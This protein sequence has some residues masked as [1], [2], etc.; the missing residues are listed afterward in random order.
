MCLY[1]YTR[2][3]WEHT[4]EKS[5]TCALAPSTFPRSI[6]GNTDESAPLQYNQISSAESLTITDIRF[7]SEKIHKKMFVENFINLY[8]FQSYFLKINGKLP[9][10]NSKVSSLS[11]L[12]I[13]PLALI[14]M[15][16]VSL[17]P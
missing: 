11:N 2:G 9:E 16:S 1:C 13:V 15:S 5:A 6:R 10:V 4:M 3:V 8:K 7:L 12:S 14:S 17:S